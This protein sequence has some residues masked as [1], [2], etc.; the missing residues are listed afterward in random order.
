MAI[1]WRYKTL[2][3]D[4]ANIW[5]FMI[6]FFYMFSN[7]RQKDNLNRVLPWKLLGIG[8]HRRHRTTEEIRGLGLWTR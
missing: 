5:I 2:V 6:H 8:T 1:P 7:F 4:M 3:F